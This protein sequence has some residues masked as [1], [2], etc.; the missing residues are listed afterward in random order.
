[1]TQLTFPTVATQIAQDTSDAYSAD[2][3]GSVEWT[4]AAD[5]LLRRGMTPAQ[6]N[7]V[8]RSKHMR[9]AADE[10]RDDPKNPTAADLVAFMDRYPRHF[11]RPALTQLVEGT[12]G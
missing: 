3:Y 10:S 4:R 8:L 5:E 12:E 11:T 9:Y 2:R 7:A 6:V 1:M